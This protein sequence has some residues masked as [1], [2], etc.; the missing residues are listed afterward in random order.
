MNACFMDY[1]VSFRDRDMRYFEFSA[2]LI[3]I[4]PRRKEKPF[5]IACCRPNKGGS[6]VSDL[7]G[8]RVQE[9]S[10]GVDPQKVR[11]GWK[12]EAIAI[13]N[14]SHQVLLSIAGHHRVTTQVLRG[15]ENQ[16]RN[17]NATGVEQSRLPR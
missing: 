4:S 17:T 9:A 14:P 3:Q 5:S 8:R 7:N 2:G 13:G 12:R 16:I 15:R 10:V 11:P 1:E 6:S